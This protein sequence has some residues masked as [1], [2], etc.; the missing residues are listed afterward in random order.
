MERPAPHRPSAHDLV[1]RL[2][3]AT[4]VVVLALGATSMLLNPAL[5]RAPAATLHDGAWSRAYQAAL[6]AASPLRGPTVALWNA[7]D[8]HLFGQAQKGVVLG[9]GGWLFSDE[10]YV[11]PADAPAVRMAWFEHLADVAATLEVD[12]V[13]LVV[14]LVPTKASLV[15]AGQPPLPAPA[16]RRYAEALTQLRERGVDT[17][18][19]RPPLRALGEAAWLR[20][21]THWTPAGASAA[22]EAVAQHLLELDPQLGGDGAT[23]LEPEGVE[24]V[25]GDLLR[26]L[27][28]GPLRARFGPA[29][30][31]IERSRL[32][33]NGAEATDLFASVDLPVTV[34]GTSYAADGR[35]NLATRLEAA[36]RGTAVLDAAEVGRG[37]AVP[38]A[39]YLGGDAY[40]TARPRVVVWELPERYLDDATALLVP[41]RGAEDAKG[42]LR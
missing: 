29:A 18:D 5:L 15:D 20:T 23:T 12:G 26:L 27:E 13:Q 9:E 22:A 31:V 39:T 11:L 6:D 38:M 14:V 16:A 41:R 4:F 7:L 42:A 37:P 10:E 19:L 30:D 36:L 34:V 33:R 8:L 21:D 40:R 17:V 32:V 28:L 3:A 35:W 25:E 24:T 2:Q 1:L